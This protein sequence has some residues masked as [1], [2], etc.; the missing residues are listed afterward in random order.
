MHHDDFNARESNENARR[1][2][3][4]A[5][6]I[7]KLGLREIIFGA[8]GIPKMSHLWLP[9]SLL[10]FS[11]PT[12]GLKTALYSSLPLIL[13]VFCKVQFSILINDLGDRST[14]LAVGKKRWIT[15]LH[16][17]V[18]YIIVLL[19]LAAGVAAVLLGRRSL[20]TIL[21]YAASAFFGLSYSL[22]PLRFKE[23]G[24]LGLL[25][26]TLS[27]LM[28]YV[29]VPWTWFESGLWQLIFLAAAVGTD[30]WIQIHFHQVVDY[31]ADL[32]NGTRTYVVQAGLERA[33]SSLK[34]AAFVASFC[35]LSVTVYVIVLAGDAGTRFVLFILVAATVIAAKI[36]TARSKAP[37]SPSSSAL[38]KELPWIYLGLTYLVF[39]ALPPVLFFFFALKEP[40]IW[41]LVLFSVFSAAGTSRQS[42]RYQDKRGRSLG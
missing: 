9:L 1:G 25:A 10:F 41:T 42:L 31:P 34:T 3:A 38:T 4:E 23:R 39:F 35:L 6:T 7:W 27:A 12:T 17:P 29:L 2:P 30:K 24:T 40:W 18:G 14:D 16:K 13:A 22:R 33:R 19:F 28:I 8:R 20:Q 26:Y 37:Q 11:V 32:K 5:P 21:F 36:Y 15:L